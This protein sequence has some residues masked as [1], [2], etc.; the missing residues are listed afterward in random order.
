M[1]TRFT[2]L[3][4]FAG[5]LVVATACGNPDRGSN[6]RDQ[7]HADSPCFNVNL[8]DGLDEDSTR[9]VRDL[10]D[11]ANYHGH[12]EP[13]AP[14]VRSQDANTRDGVNPGIELARTVNAMPEVDVDPFA[15][16][17]LLMNA[18][19]VED[20]PIDEFL[21]ISLEL[22]YGDRAANVR[23]G[24]IPLTSAEHLRGGVLVPLGPILPRATGALLDDDL[25]AANWFGD[26]IA[27]AETKRWIRTFEAYVTSEDPKISAPLSGII[28]HLGEAIDAAQSPENDRWPLQSSG[29][30]L[31][32]LLDLFFLQ[33][34][35]ILAQ[36]SDEAAIIVSD[37]TFRESLQPA[38]VS[39]HDKGHLQELPEQMLWMASVDVNEQ[40][41]RP[42][43]LSA[44]YRFLRLLS[45]ANQPIDCE[46]DFLI[47]QLEFSFPNLS[48]AILELIAEM[49]P[50]AV[51]G[52]VGIAS[53]L[54]DNL[55]AE[56]MLH[57]AVDLQICPD[58]TH[59]VVDDMRAMDVL[60]G[61]EA[62]SLLYAVVEIL[63]VM[64]N[65]SDTNQIP[66][67]ADLL[68]QVHVAGGT[69]VLEELVIDL[70]DH[71]VMVDVFDLIPALSDPE[72]YGITAGADKPVELQD[73]IGLLEWAFVVDEEKGQTGLE[74]M[75]P[76]L[77]ALLEPDETWVALDKAGLL[78]A[79][80]QTQIHH[81]MDIIPPLLQI[82]PE[83]EILD[84]LGPLLGYKPI[85][86]PLM[87]MIEADGLVT[88]LLAT[89]PEGESPWVPMAF[90]GR[91]I[92]NGTLDDLLGLVDMVLG[93]AQ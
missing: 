38:L 26:L 61:P 7:L 37:E 70:G 28:G 92:V 27:H 40:P 22:I 49:D 44:L 78:M 83:L 60:T 5:L 23:T 67:V 35:P 3:A 34:D 14:M 24:E 66:V 75:R 90:V 91:L 55:V 53:A 86:E 65:G 32:D 88:S 69:K 68:D 36:I 4:G 59:E 41:L 85:A 18:L 77:T 84:E 54:T 9:E 73:A 46:L 87:R 33:E 63:D 51:Q 76:L 20:R 19:Q 52:A 2:I 16:A 31:R 64:K 81:L 21:D 79:D 89:E 15:I 80:D 8:L 30:S 6:W 74:Q 47:A 50:D 29:D 42:A 11:C 1:R 45:A 39:L 82:D 58:L 71:S 48:V 10:F 62:Y 13:L 57:E 43:E 93:D 17:G 56:W 25:A 12:L 72:R